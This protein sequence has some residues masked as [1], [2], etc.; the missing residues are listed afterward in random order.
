M[1]DELIVAEIAK[2]GPMLGQLQI[3]FTRDLPEGTLIPWFGA[4]SLKSEIT[5]E[6][7]L[8][9]R[10]DKTNGNYVMEPAQTTDGKNAACFYTNDYAGPYPARTQNKINNLGMYNLKMVDVKDYYG[11]PYFFF[12]TIRAVKK[13]E[14]GWTDYGD[15]YWKYFEED[16]KGLSPTSLSCLSISNILALVEGRSQNNPI[17]VSTGSK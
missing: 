13:G 10:E 9:E 16:L 4:V 17:D 15:Q 7:S 11:T 12:M 14:V 5:K 8:Y 3:K 2:A 6:A 1:K